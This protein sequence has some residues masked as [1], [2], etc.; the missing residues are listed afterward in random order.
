MRTTIAM[1]TF[2]GAR[3]LKEQLDSF[4]EQTI[5]PD[6]LV[7]SDDASHDHSCRIIERFS[8]RAPFPVKL[9]RNEVNKGYCANF[10]RALTHCRGDIVFLSDQDDVWLPQKIEKV[11]SEFDKSPETQLILHDIDYCDEDLTPIGQTKIERMRSAFDLDQSY[12]VGMAA[13]IRGD[14]LR[15][16][17][18]IPEAP[19]ITH[20]NWLSACSRAVRRKM[21]I[22]DVLAKHRRHFTNAT[23]LEDLNV[24]FKT[25][26]G[27]F[28]YIAF[29]QR[30]FQKANLQLAASVAFRDWLKR[31]GNGLVEKG[32]ISSTAYDELLDRE[33]VNVCHLSERQK[34]LDQPRIMRAGPVTKFYVDGGY[35]HFNGIKS[36][37]KDMLLN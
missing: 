21:I 24:S 20:D 15:L 26:T 12:V 34:I 9:I 29:L 33:R 25:T 13:A 31:A 8:E 4:I 37:L 17:I 11:I 18:P 1:A 5:L 22:S 10:N 30:T 28:K 6:E 2:N 36:A 14:F 16:C 27:H 35:G 3:Y 7:V 19:G 32:Y 23:A